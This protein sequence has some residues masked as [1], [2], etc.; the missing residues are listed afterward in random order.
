MRC[1][2]LKRAQLWAQSPNYESR[3]LN[4]PPIEGRRQPIGYWFETYWESQTNFHCEFSAPLVDAPACT[5]AKMANTRGNNLSRQGA[6]R[7]LTRPERR[8]R[9]PSNVNLSSSPSRTARLVNCHHIVGRRAE[10]LVKRPR[11]RSPA[12]RL[13]RHR[14]GQIR[15][16]QTAGL[17][18]FRATSHPL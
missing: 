13:S 12:R 7:W 8:V 17:P 1:C 6:R 9:T 4:P 15:Q 10:L 2:A 14:R 18:G 3:N 5:G 16:E 11:T